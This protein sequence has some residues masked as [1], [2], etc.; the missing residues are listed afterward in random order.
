ME[1]NEA[2]L[3]TELPSPW[4]RRLVGAATLVMIPLFVFGGSV[5]T[6]GAG[7]A[8][9]GW[10]NAEGDFMPFFPVAKW[11]R[12]VQTFVEHS[13]RLVG[14][15]LG[16][17]MLAACV[18]TWILDR[19]KNARWFVI[20]ATLAISLQGWLGG[21]RVELN[22]PE[23]AF[24]HGSF[25]QLVFSF[26]GAVWIHQS[27][28]WRSSRLVATTSTPDLRRFAI[29]TAIAVYVQ[30]GIGAWYRHALRT[31]LAGD[32][33]ARFGVHA[34]AA[35]LV[36]VMVLALA[37]RLERADREAGGGSPYAT[38]QKRLVA[39]LWL[40]VTLG[41]LAWGLA[42][43]TQV[44]FLQWSCATLH[45]LVGA[46]LLAHATAAIL[47]ALRARGGVSGTP[48]RATLGSVR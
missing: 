42:D 44:G 38:L 32:L 46:L 8:V 39:I 10:W 13:H 24:V 29:A 3:T 15:T 48:E 19:R 27:K 35:V 33:Q 2:N 31:G 7:M 22:S 45:V 25:A 12:N 26:L 23:F 14:L 11:F 1:A 41:F 37:A 18:A 40:Q 4:P 28:S 17:L 30:I 36:I 5:T 21:L 34:L 9:K 20:A 43:P 6:L 16:V 47:W